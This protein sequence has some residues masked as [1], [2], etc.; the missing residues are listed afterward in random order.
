MHVPEFLDELALLCTVA[1]LV[2]RLFRQIKLPPVIG[3]IATG[4]LL[5]PTGLGIVEQDHVISTIAEIGVVM[6]LFTIGLEFSF[7]DIKKMRT[8]VLIGGP[9]QI[10]LTTVVSAVVVMVMLSM[11]GESIS[12]SGAI[13]TGMATAMSSTAICIKLLSE[14]R[15]LAQPQGRAALGILIFQDIAVVPMMIIASMLASPGDFNPADVA[16]RLATLGAAIAVLVTGLRFILPRLIPHLAG[17]STPEVLV[18]AAL[19][20]CFGAGWLTSMA[21]LS[22]ALGAFIAGMAIAGTEDGHDIGNAVAPLRDA[23]TSMFFLS[24]G[25]LVHATFTSLP[26]DILLALAMLITK[27][28]VVCAVLILIRV[29]IRTAV[30]AAVI[31][32]QVG[33]FSFVIATTGVAQGVITPGDY[34]NL[35]VAIII[36]MIVTPLLVTFAPIIAERIAPL[37]RHTPALRRWTTDPRDGSVHLESAGVPSDQPLVLI[38]GAGVLGSDVAH[39]LAQSG[40]P[41]RILEFDRVVGAQQR[42]NN[43]PVVIGDIADAEALRAAGIDAV[44]VVVIA[45]NQDAAIAGGVKLIR[46]LRPEV[47]IVVRVRYQ[48]LRKTALEQGADLV[49]VEEFESGVKAFNFVLQHLGVDPVMIEYQERYMR[50]KQTFG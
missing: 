29:P 45:I 41:Y 46:K 50:L 15:E 48:R 42:Q 21:G 6:L 12:T 2:V 43:E 9:L 47:Q 7:E 1:L 36:T 31:L 23:F 19:G 38:V 10:I 11:M 32:A 35:L 49:I 18:L 27:A 17:V 24:V 37:A 8:I 22:M 30:T 44:S 13:L 4:L 34:Q 28:V 20:L 26:S 40:V 39:V 5:G 14:R 33:E 16:L 3:L 25:L